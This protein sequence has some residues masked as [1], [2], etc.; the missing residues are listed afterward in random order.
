MIRVAF[1]G[2]RFREQVAAGSREL[3]GVE[4]VLPGETLAQLELR[5]RELKPTVLVIPLEEVPEPTAAKLE[6][7]LDESGAEMAVVVYSYTRKAVVH[8]LL[9][10]PRLRPVQGP[11]SLANLRVQMLQL[12]VKDIL[13]QQAPETRLVACPRCGT[14]VEER[15][16]SGRH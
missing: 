11:L 6:A 1:V 12:L 16:L 9:A 7:L 14:R 4:V 10:H 13:A 2:D 15:A 3:S 8:E 5:A